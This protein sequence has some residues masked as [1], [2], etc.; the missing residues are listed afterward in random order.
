MHVTKAPIS[1]LNSVGYFSQIII[2]CEGASSLF[3]TLK[4]LNWKLRQAYKF[5]NFKNEHYNC[6]KGLLTHKTRLLSYGQEIKPII[7]T[8]CI[9]KNNRNSFIFLISS[10]VILWSPSVFS[11]LQRTIKSYGKAFKMSRVMVNHCLTGIT[12]SSIFCNWSQECESLILTNLPNSK[13]QL[14]LAK[15]STLLAHMNANSSHSR[16][17]IRMS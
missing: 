14:E 10:I 15:M 1:S 5:Q 13:V 3:L 17:T 11:E 6:Y 4:V 9:S 16:W 7:N 12:H 8:R 2:C